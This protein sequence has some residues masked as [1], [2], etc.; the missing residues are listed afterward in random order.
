[1]AR[2]EDLRRRRAMSQFDLA[3]AAGVSISTIYKLEHGRAERVRP[4]SA[5]AIAEALGVTPEEVDELRPTLGLPAVDAAPKAM[6]A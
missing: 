4:K 1:V 6:A 3:S 2:L 5:R